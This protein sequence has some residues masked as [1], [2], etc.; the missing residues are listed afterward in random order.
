MPATRR[1]LRASS[2]SLPAPTAS[3]S[4]HH[5][6]ADDIALEEASEILQ[7]PSVSSV[8][9]EGSSTP[10]ARALRHA[11][12]DEAREHAEHAES[13]DNEPG[14][15]RR[16]TRSLSKALSPDTSLR[17]DSPLATRVSG[18]RSTP[19]P[20]RSSRLSIDSVA[21]FREA[22][23]VADEAGS[24]VSNDDGHPPETISEGAEGEDENGDEE[25]KSLT[26]STTESEADSDV[27]SDD[28]SSDSDTDSE[29]QTSSKDDS[30]DSEEE[31]D[32]LEKLLQA[33]RVSV[34]TSAREQ[35]PS[36]LGDRE[37]RRDE[38]VL[39]FDP[40][41]EEEKRHR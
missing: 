1:S 23:T 2:S 8:Q 13:V 15:S 7:S 20:R 19:Q 5:R 37:S 21:A 31:E 33:A 34:Q 38:A 39:Q 28:S 16:T 29:A 18:V 30:D 9:R 17:L 32:Q 25:A 4:T 14:P 36:D 22:V 12:L 24:A 35:A 41:E 6:S 27:A 11:K 3:P 26:A 10:S 40:E